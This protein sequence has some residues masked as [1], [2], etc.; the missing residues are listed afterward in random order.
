[1]PR[2]FAP[3]FRAI[4][5]LDDPAFRAVVLRSLAWSLACFAGLQACAIWMV[6]RLLAFHGALAWVVDVLGSVGTL[7]LALWLFLPVAAGIGTLYCD[8][9]AS[10]VERRFYPW[11]PRAESA[12]LLVQAWD[13]IAVALRVLTLSIAGFVLAFVV[14]G[15]GLVLAWMIASY[16]IGR[17]LFV[18]VAMRR[19][20]RE[21]AMELYRRNRGI[22]LTQ[23]AML[24]VAGYIPIMNLMMPVLG[25]AAMVHILDMASTAMDDSGRQSVRSRMG[26]N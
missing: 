9:I 15:L 4:A 24:A 19:M 11:L 7:V 18:A 23:G 12:P 17:G 1:M 2:L 6:H 20:P 13:G 14:P 16:A 25:V 8:Q 10:A 21:V 22:V 3:M 26:T 5:Q